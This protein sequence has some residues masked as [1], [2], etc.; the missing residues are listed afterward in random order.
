MAAEPRDDVTFDLVLG[1]SEVSPS[2]V[3][4]KTLLAVGAVLRAQAMAGAMENILERTVEYANAR[5]QFGKPIGR[6]QAIQQNLAV[7]ATQVAAAR[8]GADMAADAWS[9]DPEDA[10]AFCAA[11][12][13]AKIRA[14]E[15]AGLVAGIAHQTHGAIGF[16]L[17]YPLHPFTRRRWAWREEFG[18]ESFWAEQLGAQVCALVHQNFWPFLTQSGV[19]A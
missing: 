19:R 10:D 15:A 4:A 14:G 9:L 3:T 13:A 2:P 12:A 17:E 5:V 8:A 7:M 16:S 11:A 1:L 6:F 18:A